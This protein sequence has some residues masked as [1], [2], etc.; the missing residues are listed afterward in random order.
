MSRSIVWTIFAKE[1]LDT[2]RDKRTLIAMIGVPIFLYPALVLLL[3]EVAVSQS[4]RVAAVD[5]RVGIVAENP[6]PIKAW[7]AEAE[8]IELVDPPDPDAALTFGRIDAIVRVEESLE[9]IHTDN[10]TLE[11]Q[12]E[13]DT[14]ESASRLALSRIETV[15]DE[16]EQRL[17]EDRLE[18]QDLP[19][20]FANP[21]RI[22]YEP[23]EEVTKRAG[24]L[25]G[26]ILPMIIV[27]MM[28]LGGFYPAVDL[29]AGEKERGT[30]E[31]L[32]STPATKLDILAGKFGAVVTLA[33]IT[34]LLNVLSSGLTIWIYLLQLSEVG[35]EAVAEF[36]NQILSIPPGRVALMVLLLVPLAF[37]IASLMMTVAVFA[38]SFKDAQ[39]YLTPLFIAITIPAV[40]GVLPDFELT[41][42]TRF[43]PIG[44][45][46]LLA[47]EVMMDQAILEDAFFVLLSTVIYAL[48]AFVLAA[49]VFQSEEVILSQ[50]RG[51]PL[52]LNRAAFE[53]HDTPTPGLALA[54]FAVVMMLVMYFGSLVQAYN[55]HIGLVITEYL[56]VLAPALAILW[57]ARI[58]IRTALNL[59][60]TAPVFWFGAALAAFGW[61][62]IN[63]QIGLASARVLPLP[64]EL[65]ETLSGLFAI[66]D[67]LP[68]AVLLLLLIGVT[69]AICEE[70]VFR[71][72]LLSGLRGRMP[73]WAVV[74][75]IGLLF[76]LFHLT[77]YRFIPT[78]ATGLV[79][80]YVA[81]RGNSIGLSML[82]HALFNSTLVL[83]QLGYAPARVIDL[84]LRIEEGTTGIPAQ[85]M[86]P[87]VVLFLGGIAAIEWAARRRDPVQ[88]PT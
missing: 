43:I 42:M 10:G 15:L 1:L 28:G 51:M 19:E 86:V 54:I 63:L 50:E 48:A 79:L 35:G 78:A 36:G 70:V 26:S 83:L 64:P 71:G 74:L 82:F 18:V 37:I 41:E 13:F 59:R 84:A 80:T 30:F 24:F 5:S 62:P 8:S 49:R 29:T 87:A 7:F 66:G 27:L 12:L 16:Q 4:A 11:V 20:T 56:F 53:P 47:R 57:F 38:R 52:T 17:L 77:I 72:A 23:V 9:D 65:Q 67:T 75:V 34:G 25:L 55:Q 46:M 88:N 39:N 14:T 85:V 69:P 31:T 60:P 73:N 21:F 6:E 33:L 44:N 68:G 32:L 45:V 40:L 61:I 58:R 76:G 3:S 22:K 2:L 81:L